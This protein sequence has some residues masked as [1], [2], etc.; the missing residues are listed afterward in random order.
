MCSCTEAIFHSSPMQVPIWPQGLCSGRLL[1]RALLQ[2]GS[3]AAALPPQKFAATFLKRRS[4]AATPLNSRT[5][6]AIL[7]SPPVSP[8]PAPRGTQH[9]PAQVCNWT[10]HP[11]GNPRCHRLLFLS[12]RASAPTRPRFRRDHRSALRHLCPVRGSCRLLST[13]ALSCRVLSLFRANARHPQDSAHTRPNNRACFRHRDAHT[14]LL[15]RPRTECDNAFLY[16]LLSLGKATQRTAWPDPELH[17]LPGSFLYLASEIICRL[18]L[19][20]PNGDR[21]GIVLV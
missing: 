5:A 4:S 2:C 18:Y 13:A 16:R 8:R 20:T 1:R 17:R 10:S 12:H 3:P 6:N 11:P 7:D 19:N 15:L 9:T 14:I 21:N